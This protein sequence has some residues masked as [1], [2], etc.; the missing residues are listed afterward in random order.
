MA[1]GLFFTLAAGGDFLVAW[2]I[3]KQKKEDLIQDHPD[4]IGCLMLEKDKC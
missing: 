2:M 3:R 1:Y 4:R